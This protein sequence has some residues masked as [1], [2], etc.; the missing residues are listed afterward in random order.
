MRVII[1]KKRNFFNSSLLISSF[2]LYF[3]ICNITFAYLMFLKVD[4]F[5]GIFYNIDQIYKLWY[6]KDENFYV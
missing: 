2:P 5:N 6:K 4:F 1:Y 3:Q